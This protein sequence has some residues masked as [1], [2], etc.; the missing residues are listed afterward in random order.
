[1]I[2]N[3]YSVNAKDIIWSDDFNRA[4]NAIIG[5]DW[6]EVEGGTSYADILSNRMR[7]VDTG[8]G[9]NYVIAKQ[10]DLHLVVGDNLT[11][12]TFIEF[13]YEANA[14]TAN[15]QLF[16]LVR[17]STDQYCIYMLYYLGYLTYYVSG[18][19]N[20]YAM[21]INIQY[22]ITLTDINFTSKTFDIYVDGTIR[23]IMLGF[24]YCL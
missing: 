14:T 8:T 9:S 4:N 2:L 12:E 18:Y 23:K 6:T 1:M 10:E 11:E 16:T 24:F 3:T 7:F 17:D 19:N 13:E 22:N 15:P 20:V 5:N 21:S